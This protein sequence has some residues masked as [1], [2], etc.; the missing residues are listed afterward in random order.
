M[1]THGAGETTDELPT[2]YPCFER[3]DAMQSF[4]Y[5]AW[6]ALPKT[7]IALDTFTRR[8]HNTAMRLNSAVFGQNPGNLAFATQTPGATGNRQQATGNRQQATGNRQQATGN[9]IPNSL[10]TMS[11]T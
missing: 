7:K 6:P 10:L 11:S 5:A 8:R 9:I 2:N 4:Q 1:K 3:E